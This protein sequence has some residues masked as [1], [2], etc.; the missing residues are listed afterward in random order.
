MRR[1]LIVL[2][3][4]LSLTILG[5]LQLFVFSG[6]EQSQKNSLE[7]KTGS[8]YQEIVNP[9]GFVNTNG[10]PVQIRDYIGK[11]IILLEFMT[12]TCVNCQRTFPYIVKWY[13]TYKDA[14]LMVIGIHTP[15]FAFEKEIDNVE[16]AMAK[17]RITFP[18]VL[19]NDYSTWNA[20]DNNFWPRL[21]LIDL[22]GNIVYD[23]IGEGKY[24]ETEAKIQE[25]IKT[26]KTL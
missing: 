12:Y 23:H 16:K 7:V 26:I 18:V 6:E 19:D 20:Y 2:G 24:E 8:Q 3:I 5:L 22:E 11:K 15:E 10:V 21:Y 1:I 13:D 9:S 25:L 14:G 4:V 17:S